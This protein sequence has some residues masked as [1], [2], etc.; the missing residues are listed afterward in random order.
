MVEDGGYI[1]NNGYY[2]GY[3]S[4][5]YWLVVMWATLE[6]NCPDS[7]ARKGQLIVT[8]QLNV[9]PI[10]LPINFLNPPKP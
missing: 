1:Y 10:P 4:G 3:N 9:K 2:G 8:K 5:Q 7:S 6:R